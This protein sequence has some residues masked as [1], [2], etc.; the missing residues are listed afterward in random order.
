MP[1]LKPAVAVGSVQ[2]TFFLA[3]DRG[4]MTSRFIVEVRVLR[5]RR[6]GLGAPPQPL[7]FRI[8]ILP[9]GRQ[10]GARPGEERTG[11]AWSAAPRHS[12]STGPVG[13]GARSPLLEYEERYV[14]RW[15]SGRRGWTK[16]PQGHL[17]HESSTSVPVR[18]SPR[19][20]LQPMTEGSRHR[21]QGG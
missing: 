8:P 21:K 14:D 3:H 7:L 15:L 17:A 13:A 19:C 16:A 5:Q 12:A 10:G 6:Q 2:G 1:C 11:C 20:G 18:T 9:I 4:R